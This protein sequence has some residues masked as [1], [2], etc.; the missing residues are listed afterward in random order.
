MIR[1]FT[2]LVLIPIIFG[3]CH[4]LTNIKGIPIQKYHKALYIT[5]LIIII[6]LINLIPF[7]H[8]YNFGNFIKTI[9][10]QYSINEIK[11]KFLTILHIIFILMSMNNYSVFFINTAS[12]Y[13]ILTN[14]IFNIYI[15]LEILNIS[16]VIFML[17]IKINKKI[18][19]EYMIANSAAAC[20]ILLG[21]G[22]IY[23]ESGE[24]NNNY[25]HSEIANYIITIGFLLKLPI[26][27]NIYRAYASIKDFEY[28]SCI[29]SLTI[30]FALSSI[31]SINIYI[32]TTA[33]IISIA[34]LIQSSDTQE[35]ILIYSS[36][37]SI[38]TLMISNFYMFLIYDSIAK[39]ILMR[40]YKQYNFIF[41]VLSFAIYIDCPVSLYYFV[42]KINLI[43]QL[44]FAMKI[45]F[46]F[47]KI[48]LI[49]FAYS[50]F[51][52]FSDKTFKL[53]Y[54]LIIFTLLLLFYY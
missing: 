18:I 14:D 24:L 54:P 8:H 39:F 21:I 27:K 36:I 48:F 20:C 22:F 38:F 50:I 46:I 25:Y 1:I 40:S 19:L 12:N 30:M 42:E 16:L 6:C 4:K 31:M 51:I 29:S 3:L 5:Y 49:Y 52:H 26:N 43:H 13:L 15:A 32:A 35:K 17:D 47:T 41:G 34:L 2:L 7:N 28:I 33:I 53:D 37:N 11:T 9:S 10:I 44:S 45:V 23:M